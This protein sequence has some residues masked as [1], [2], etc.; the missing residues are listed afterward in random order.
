MDRPDNANA[1][2]GDERS[3]TRRAYLRTAVTAAAVGA[4]AGCGRQDRGPSS[5][6]PTETTRTTPDEGTNGT[7]TGEAADSPPSELVERHGYESVVNV[8]NAGADPNG[9]ESVRPVL[10]ANASDDTLLYF[11][12]GRYR[13]DE[14]SATDYQNLGVVGDDA[15]LV[16]PKRVGYW[17]K[18]GGLDDLLFEGFTID[19]RPNDVAP[20]ARVGTAGGKS[21]VRNVAVRGHRHAPR[22]AFEIEVTDSDGELTFE[23]VSL[24]DGST[25]GHAMYVFP[26]SVGTLTFRNCRLE[27]WKEGLYAAYHRGPLRVLGGYYANNGI[28][29]VRVGGGTSGALVR[30]V[31]VRVDNPRQAQHK[32]NMRGIWAEE[33]ASARIEDCDIAITDLTGTYSS[34][35]IVVG[36]QFGEVT[37]INTRVRTDADAYAV[38]VRDPIESMEGQTVPS[39]DRLPERTRFTARDL[40]ISGSAATG[41]AVRAVRR[42]DC[43]FERVCIEHGGER[44]GMAFT[45]AQGC[46]VRDSTIDVGGEAIRSENATVTKRGVRTDESC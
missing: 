7:A 44:D 32:P 14:W 16:P 17:L 28:E 41:T 33:G 2:S 37:V 36:T 4:L 6:E 26:E 3:A 24:P 12:A 35:G 34:G 10:E 31:T 25:T 22:T 11:P 18:W 45:D 9:E 27:H 20:I 15:V 19:C 8:V 39:M 5:P 38:S 13:L 1:T 30:G 43:R 21:F 46:S 40:R 42:N 23:N 29:Q